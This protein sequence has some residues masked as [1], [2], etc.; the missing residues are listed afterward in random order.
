MSTCLF[1]RI[2]QRDI[3]AR[4]AF[5]DS[6]VLAFHDIN[7]QAPTH[8]LVIPKEH[9]ATVAALRPSSAGI[10]AD[11]VLAANRLAREL[12]VAEQGYRLVLN[13]GE[14]AGQS[15]WHLHLHLLGGRAFAWPPG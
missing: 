13:C 1:C 10:M 12:G 3:P 11:L 4:I 6:R 15:V 5:E 14:Q 8:V 2:V 9:L 7:P